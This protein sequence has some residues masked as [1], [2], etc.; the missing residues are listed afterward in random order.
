MRSLK[1]QR[2]FSHFQTP[3][4]RTEHLR[5]NSLIRPLFGKEQGVEGPVSKTVFPRNSSDPGCGDS[6]VGSGVKSVWRRPRKVRS[7]GDNPWSVETPKACKP[8]Y[9]L[10][11][12]RCCI[13]RTRLGLSD[14]CYPALPDA[15]HTLHTP[16]HPGTEHQ[17]LFW[18]RCTG[19][20]PCA[21]YRVSV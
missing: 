17:L 9:P 5:V 15:P 12:L 18:S 6:H 3:Q 16:P 2:C 11:N 13:F 19:A 8:L 1:S 14:L 4:L 20:E 21:S 10:H 7:D